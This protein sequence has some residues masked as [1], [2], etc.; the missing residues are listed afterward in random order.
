MTAET[1]EIIAIIA[2]ILEFSA[3]L[4]KKFL[5]RQKDTVSSQ[6]E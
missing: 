4:L 6:A 2:R 1:K 5:L 3:S